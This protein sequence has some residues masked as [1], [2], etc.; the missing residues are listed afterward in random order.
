M[1]QTLIYLAFTFLGWLLANNSGCCAVVPK[2]SIFEME[3]HSSGIYAIPYK[4]VSL[5]AIFSG[6]DNRLMKVSGFWDG[7][8]SFKIR[9]TPTIEGKWEYKTSS[10]DPGLD[11][12]T[13]TINCTGPA[14]ATHGF[15]RRDSAY[16]YHF[17]YDAGTRYFL[18]GQTY[19]HLVSYALSG[20]NWKNSIDGTL[21]RGMNKIR[22]HIGIKTDM[23]PDMVNHWRLVDEITGY[24]L[25]RNIT[26]DFIIFNTDTGDYTTDEQDEAF[27]KYVISRYAAYPNVSWCLVNEWNY[28]SKQRDYWNRMGVIASSEDP[29]ALENGMVR[30]LSIHQQTRINFQFFDQKWMS[31]AIIQYGVRNKDKDQTDEWKN[32]GITR[33]RNGDEW[34]NSG[35]LFNMGHNMPVVNDEY[36]YIGEPKDDSEKPSISLTREKHRNIIWG[37]YTAGGYG[38]AGDKYSYG[39]EGRPYSQ[40]FWRDPVEYVDISNLVKFFTTKG[41]QFWRMSSHNEIIKSGTRVYALA[42]PGR[43]YVI[44]AAEGGSFELFL[45]RGKYETRCFNPVTAEDISLGKKMGGKIRKFV[46]EPGSDRVVYLISVKK[47]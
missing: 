26:A 36:G 41:L 9:F 11:K 32:T 18:F 2:W 5:T 44:Y 31:H 46:L 25:S 22:F 1:K 40:G 16:K 7:G 35:I 6:P 27:L 28:R 47:F 20:G 10:N 13:G 17:V 37:I 42:E 45:D 14:P 33:Y 3:L 21:S 15:I 23:N 12:K 8:N 43:Q 4:E 34:G 39:Q 30:M 38:S 19:Y 29:W 24:M